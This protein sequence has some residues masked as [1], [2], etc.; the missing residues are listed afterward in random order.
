MYFCENGTIVRFY[1]RAK[2]HTECR[3]WHLTPQDA[4]RCGKGQHWQGFSVI[5]NWGRAADEK[6]DPGYVIPFAATAPDCFD[7]VTATMTP[8]KKRA[9][10]ACILKAVERAVDTPEEEKRRL[11]AYLQPRLF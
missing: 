10:L 2:D 5:D 8:E 6:L 3:H 4:R 1:C 9:K 7:D 11:R